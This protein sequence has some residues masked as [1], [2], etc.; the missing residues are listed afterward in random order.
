MDKNINRDLIV[1]EN[2]GDEKTQAFA[3][4]VRE[5]LTALDAEQ[6]SLFAEGNLTPDGIGRHMSKI[7]NE[8]R[9]ELEKDASF[10]ATRSENI[11]AKVEKTNQKADFSG[12][13]PQ[14]RDAALKGLQELPPKTRQETLATLERDRDLC[15]AIASITP[16]L[17][18]LAYGISELAHERATAIAYGG[19]RDEAGQWRFPNQEDHEALHR[20]QTNHTRALRILKTL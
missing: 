19:Q 20:A 8:A 4:K 10:Y 2:S 6:N 17:A 1:L 15:M 12:V 16:S 5:R 18:K 3:S 7:R 13:D 14:L 9:E 11:A